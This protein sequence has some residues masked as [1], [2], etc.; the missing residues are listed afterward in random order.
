MRKEKVYIYIYL[1]QNTNSRSH[2]NI[3]DVQVTCFC[4]CSCEDF[5]LFVG[6]AED[7]RCSAKRSNIRACGRINLLDNVFDLLHH[8][9]KIRYC[10]ILQ[11]YEAACTSIRSCKQ[12]HRMMICLA[13][14]GKLNSGASDIL[15]MLCLPGFSVTPHERLRLCLRWQFSIRHT[16]V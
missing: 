1:S 4:Y 13:L 3:G 15:Y 14:Q 7:I 11:R 8:K 16:L 12:T 5:R 10:Y 2:C 6:L 9:T